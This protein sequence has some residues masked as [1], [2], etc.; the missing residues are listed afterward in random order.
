MSTRSQLTKDLNESIKSSVGNKVKILFKN[1]VRLETKGDKTENRVLLCEF[2]QI[3]KNL[4]K[5]FNT[6]IIGLALIIALRP[7]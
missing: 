2:L 5:P 1:V 3:F 7:C 6:Q 4:H